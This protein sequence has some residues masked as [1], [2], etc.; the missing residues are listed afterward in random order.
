MSGYK[1][2][3]DL[4]HILSANAAIVQ[5]VFPLVSQAVRFVAEEGAFRWK[6]AVMHAKLWPEGEKAPYVESIKWRMVGPYAAEITTD[7][8]LAGEIET[9]R[10]AKDLKKILQTSRKT[11]SV[12]SGPHVGMRYLIIPFRHNIPSGT[13]VGAYARQMPSH[14]YAAAKKLTPSYLLPPGSVK[15]AFRLSASG[16]LVPQHS[17][18]WGGR[19]PEGLAPKL[20]PHHKTDPYAGMVRF[21]TTTPGTAF[22]KPTKSSAY[23]T[24][25][26]MGEWSSGWVIPPRPGLYI[27]KNVAEGL[28]PILED[29]IGQAVSLKAISGK[30][31]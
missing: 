25:R 22:K 14:I 24:F 29:A 6:Q 19:L 5:S 11:R 15:P 16:H 17:Y 20:A 9:G 26:T 12:K 3:V 8:K 21:D 23:L 13:G 30:W 1:I 7:F 27:A 10:P 2:S 31:S 4:S 18:K 28:K